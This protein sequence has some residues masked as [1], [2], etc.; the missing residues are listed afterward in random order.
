MSRLGHWWGEVRRR[1]VLRV[2]VWYL[3]GAWVLAQVADL[4]FDAFDLAGY[5]RFVIGALVAGLPVALAL[6]WIFDITPR[7]IERTLALAPAV[8]LS[9]SR[10]K[11]SL[12]R[13][14]DPNA[15]DLLRR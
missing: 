3:A 10:C 12:L 4:L 11:M 15:L 9:A 6:A 8:V 7:G 5:T 14:G 2:A 13:G 1:R